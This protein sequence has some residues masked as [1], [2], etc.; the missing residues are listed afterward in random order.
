MRS[1]PSSVH[2][3]NFQ[4]K[5]KIHHTG[6]LA[7]YAS[8]VH[9]ASLPVRPPPPGA[10]IPLMSQHHNPRRVSSADALTAE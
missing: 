10:H 4:R 9:A 6:I 8:Y 5:G 3:L 2:S 1:L 7:S